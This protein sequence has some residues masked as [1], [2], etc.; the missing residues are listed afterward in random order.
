MHL[1]PPRLVGIS[2]GQHDSGRRTQD[3]Y[4]IPTRRLVTWIVLG[5]NQVRQVT[6]LSEEGGPITS[7][8]RL[9]ERTSEIRISDAH[10]GPAGARD[11]Q[12]VPTYILRGLTRLHLDLR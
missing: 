11:Y 2:P 9:L 5:R 1:G 4:D 8:E 7:I 6:D 10:H 12:Y 3:G